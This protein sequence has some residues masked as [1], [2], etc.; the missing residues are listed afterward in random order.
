VIVRPKP[1]SDYSATPLTTD[2]CNSLV[3]FTDNSQLADN[4]FYW[5]DDSI[6]FSLE[7]NPSYLFLRDGM[8]NTYQV[9]TS[10]YGCKDTSRLM[11]YIEPFTIYVPNAFT[12]NE[13]VF[14]K[15]FLPIVYHPAERW[16]FQIFN[17]WGELIFETEDQNEA[18]DG[19]IPSG[20]MAQDGVYVWKITYTSC[21]PINP[22]EILTGTVTLLR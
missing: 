11:I 8:H 5:F 4:Y 22:E 20:E 6:A 19:K 12:P 9:V 3:D 16:L 14:N 1:V 18:W 15:E 13:D 2:I 17:R 21:E 7:Q 10:E